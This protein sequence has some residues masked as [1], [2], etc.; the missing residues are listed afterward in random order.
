MEKCVVG[1]DWC[2]DFGRKFC[3]LYACDIDVL[4]CD[5]VFE[6]FD[7]VPDSVDVKLEEGECVWCCWVLR[8]GRGCR[9][10]RSGLMYRGRGMWWMLSV[11]LRA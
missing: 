1:N 5:E 10:C 9:L 4:L 11:G 8:G 6:F 3:F 7:F 2:S